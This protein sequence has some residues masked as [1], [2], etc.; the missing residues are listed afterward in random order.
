MNRSQ[1]FFWLIAF[2]VCLFGS[3][4]LWAQKETTVQKPNIIL[5]MGDDLTWYDIAPYGSKQ[6]RTPNLSSLA[7]EGMCFDNMFT[8]SPACAPTRQQLLTGVY[9][10][11]NGA[12]P[13]HSRVY[14]G[15]RSVA[16]HLQGLGYR[17]ALIGKRHFAPEESYPFEFLGGRNGDNGEGIDIELQKAHAFIQGAK[18]KPYFLM[19]TSNQPHGPLTRGD[20]SAYPPEK[21]VLPPGFVDTDI[22]RAQLSKYYAEITYLDSLVGV[23]LNM[24]E[25]S[26]ETDNTLVIFTSEQGSGF[27]FAKW[28]LYDAGLKTAFIVKWP[29]KV[30]PSSRNKAFAQYVDIVPTLVDIAGGVP[31]K[32]N[33]GVRDAYGYTGFDGKSFKSILLGHS[34]HLRDQVYG[35]QTTR[36]IINGSKSYPVRSVRDAQY[37]FIHNLDPESTFQ[38]VLTRGALFKSWLLKDPAR[39]S[40]YTKRPEY[41][42][43]DVVKDP[44]QLVN[45]AADPSLQGVLVKMK[46]KLAAF[47]KQQGDKGLATEMDANNRKPKNGEDE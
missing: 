45:V 32:I 14:N 1:N 43:Y 13:N 10:V 22:T 15:T 4:E 38:N 35:V 24:V 30:K 47:M 34:T 42:L 16:H 44:N 31:A 17:T 6:V 8:A 12:H 18:D 21:I 19:V 33:T 3:G 2:L 20:A 37:L 46:E 7:K 5:I 29:G 11:R 23:V 40:L 26:G 28:T 9:P 25:K 41:E 39:A 27:P 36:G